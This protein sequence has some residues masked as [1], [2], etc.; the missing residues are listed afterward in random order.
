MKRGISPLI[1]WVLII[2]FAIAI[3][4]VIIP[5]LINQIKDWNPDPDI[6]YC[7]DVTLSFSNACRDAD[8]VLHLN[9]TNNGDF[10]IKKITLGRTTNVTAKQWCVYSEISS[11]MPLVPG[12]KIELKLSLD[13]TFGYN[14][15]STSPPECLDSASPGSLT[16]AVSVDLIPWIKPDPEMEILQC[17]NRKLI[18]DNSIILN[19]NC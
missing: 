4:L 15:T 12:N 8:G 18:L 14:I 9:V 3:G 13:E 11:Y 1:S 16:Q 7:N 2:S 19:T 6:D 5:A 10:S 17:N